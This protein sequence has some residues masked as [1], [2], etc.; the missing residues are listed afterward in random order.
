MA[1]V[2]MVIGSLAVLSGAG[3]ALSGRALPWLRDR[4]LR[5][6]PWG[7]GYLLLGLGLILMGA[8]QSDH[9]G[10]PVFAVPVVL[11]AAA[12]TLMLLGTRGAVR[13]R[14]G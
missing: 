9:S 2:L 10:G 6:V 12:F 11:V 13:P 14:R 3:V 1:F 8:L 7:L 5:P 4:T